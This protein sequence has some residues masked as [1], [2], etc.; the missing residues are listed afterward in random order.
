MDH[1]I[2]LTRLLVCETELQAKIVK[3]FLEEN[4]IKVMVK[5]LD[6]GGAVFGGAVEDAEIEIFV[7]VDDL[8]KTQELLEALEEEEGDPVP[9][10]IC[11][12]GEEVDE[13]FELCWSCGAEY[14]EPTG[15]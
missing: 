12:C 8:E 14:Q 1:E 11:K 13:G 3:G 10:W 4:G 2:E 9:E 15:E 5:G 6:T 7:S